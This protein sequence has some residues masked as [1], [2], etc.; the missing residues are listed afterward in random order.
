MTTL[1]LMYIERY[2]KMVVG[3]RLTIE[4]V[5]IKYQEEVKKIV[6]NWFGDNNV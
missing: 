1:D 2:A 6:D 4:Q 5:P 3:N